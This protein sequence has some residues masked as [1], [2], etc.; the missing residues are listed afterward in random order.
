MTKHSFKTLNYVIYKKI[1]L[2]QKIL[3]IWSMGSKYRLLQS[4]WSRSFESSCLGCKALLNYKNQEILNAIL[5]KQR[6]TLKNQRNINVYVF[7]K[8]GKW[9]ARAPKYGI[10]KRMSLSRNIKSISIGRYISYLRKSNIL[11]SLH[12]ICTWY[13]T[14]LPHLCGCQQWHRVDY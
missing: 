9:Y 1:P 6:K 2:R 10:Y 14:L 12:C 4:P 7:S 5:V 8:S 11:V 3:H 13:D